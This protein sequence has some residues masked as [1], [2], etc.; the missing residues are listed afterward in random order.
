MRLLEHHLDHGAPTPAGLEDGELHLWCS[1]PDPAVPAA[2][3]ERLLQ[4]EELAR[5]RS[6]GMTPRRR[7]YLQT[8]A[9]VRQALS[10]YAPTA[11]SAWRFRTGPH[12]RPELDLPSPLR[13]NLSNC[14][15]LVTCLVGMDREI[16][17]DVEPVD[18]A[19]DVLELAERILSPAERRELD[20][21]ATTEARH[22]LALSL[23]TLKEAYLKA[24]G[25]GLTLPPPSLSFST[26]PG[27]I[28]LRAAADIEP[29]PEG[30]TFASVTLGRHRV[31]VAAGPGPGRPT[32]LRLRHLIPLPSPLLRVDTRTRLTSCAS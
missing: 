29:A 27:A 32:L 23:W 22:D 16:G 10:A 11:P 1:V 24:R 5:S 25:L 13:F 31:A 2:E 6:M 20:G 9:L 26:A 14:Q 4:P 28:S 18:R 3:L 21:L 7:E 15:G 30:W 8:R 17:V 12:G 19:A